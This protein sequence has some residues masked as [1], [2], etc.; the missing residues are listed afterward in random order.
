MERR[1]HGARKCG[2]ARG[3][4][5][6]CVDG[7]FGDSF[8]DTPHYAGSFSKHLKD[9]HS[10]DLRMKAQSRD[11]VLSTQLMRADEP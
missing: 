10:R 8:S 1:H 2:P 7:L 11:A 9:R 6:D 5:D 3:Y 4:R